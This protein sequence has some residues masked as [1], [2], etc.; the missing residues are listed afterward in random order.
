MKIKELMGEGIVVLPGAFNG[1]SA[2][3]VEKAGFKAFYISG[4]GLVNGVAAMPDVGL[5]TMSEVQTQASYIVNAVNIPCI[6]DGDTGFGE[7]VNVMRMVKGLEGIGAAGVH[8]EDQELPKKCGHL[9]G[10]KLVSPQAMAEKIASAVEARKDPD[11]IIIARTDARGV[12][13]IKNAIERANIY[14]EAGADVIFPEALESKEE[15]VTFKKEVNAPLLANMTEFGKT[16][17]ITVSEFED[18]GYSIV[19]FPLTTFRVMIKAV[20]D[21]LGKLKAEGTQK[22]LI[23]KMLTRKELYELID[24]NEYE[25]IDKKISDK[26]KK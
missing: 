7:T 21:A 15:F 11:F 16:P 1:I 12:E 22:D 4:A 2:K 18:I 6:V 26:I 9:S 23:E 13:D 20:Q 5:L 19:I 3:L 10:K 14:L 25:G 17:L 8:I 24:Y